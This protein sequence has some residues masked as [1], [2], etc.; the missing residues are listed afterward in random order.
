MSDQGPTYTRDVVSRR[1]V[2][3]TVRVV[4]APVALAVVVVS[5]CSV[6]SGGKPYSLTATE[7]CLRTAGARVAPSGGDFIGQ[8]AIRGTAEVRLRGKTVSVAFAKDTA[9][10][11]A[12]LHTYRGFGGAVDP[13]LYRQGSA[14]LSWYAEPGSAKNIVNGCLR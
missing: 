14:V 9:G 1:N 12:V 7:T 8:T 10:A 5:G 4:W 11:A 2:R 6:A 3:L 13:T